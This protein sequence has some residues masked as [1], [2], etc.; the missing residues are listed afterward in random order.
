MVTILTLAL[1]LS[2]EFLREV[3]GIALR[4][5]VWYRA[6]DEIER[7]I[8]NLT[9]SVVES[10]K[11]PTLVREISKILA[12]LREAF[13]SAFIKHVENYGFKKLMD[14]INVAVSLGNVEALKWGSESFARLLAVNNYNN[15]VGWRQ[16]A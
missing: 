12:K 5:R 14:V 15:P 13:K 9:I 3:R 16:A 8:V 10:V 4:K 7:G 2:K 11:S 1:M 6:L